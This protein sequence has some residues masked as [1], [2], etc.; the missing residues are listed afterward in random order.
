MLTDSVPAELVD[1]VKAM[2]SDFHPAGQRALVRA[3]FPEHDLR[4][5]LN[6]TTCRRPSFTA[7]RMCADETV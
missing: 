7:T 3:G 4:D 5:V 1:E 2:L 6:A